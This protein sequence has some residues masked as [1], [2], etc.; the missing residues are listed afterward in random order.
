ML[1]QI[2]AMPLA[3][4]ETTT[5]RI[6]DVDI[7]PCGAGSGGVT[8]RRVSIIRHQ[9]VFGLD[10]YLV[11]LESILRHFRQIPHTYCFLSKRK[12]CVCSG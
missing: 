10:L 3:M 4:V 9:R 2:S 12:I 8:R 6:K 5:A 7:W 1:A 11:R